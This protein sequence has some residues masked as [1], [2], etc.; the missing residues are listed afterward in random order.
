MRSSR[1]RRFALAATGLVFAGI[2]LASALAPHRMAEGLGYTLSNV[3]ALSEFRAVYVGLWTATAV[4][5]WIAARR[6]HEPLLG[7][8]CA[9]LVLGQVAGRLLS[10]ALDGLPTP[11]MWPI[12]GLEAV[13][14]AVL[15]GVRPDR[16]LLG[17]L[18]TAR[19]E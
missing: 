10:L 4:A 8:L 1:F 2:A 11:R 14:A 9:L 5:F 16:Q 17:A 6:V 13:G 19:R 12:A 15:L 7:D 18:S 3:D